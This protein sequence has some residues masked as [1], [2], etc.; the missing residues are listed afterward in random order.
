MKKIF[1]IAVSLITTLSTHPQHAA[2]S[3]K[4][5]P[6]A[7]SPELG[8][9]LFGDQGDGDEGQKHVAN[10]MK[11]FCQTTRCDFGLILGDNF[12][13]N[14]VRG[15][16]DPQF[17][18]AFE[19]P[20]SPLAIPFYAVLGNHDYGYLGVKGNI[21]AQVD[22]TQKSKFWKMP[23]RYYAFEEKGVQFVALD[24]VALEDEVQQEEWMVATL[25]ESKAKYKVV[26]GHFPIHSGGI[27]GDTP[28]MRK[29]ISPLLCGRAS[30]YVSGHDH[31]LQH[32]KTDCG[33][34]L[35]VSGAASS[36]RVVLDTK[37]SEF[38]K[39]TLGFAYLT[40]NSAGELKVS[41]VNDQLQ[42]LA[43]FPLPAAGAVGSSKINRKQK[44][45]K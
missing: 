9:L 24:T 22:Y 40:M 26:F 6:V 1:Y 4:P 17:K 21:Q 7:S 18:S 45:S 20:Y 25:N 35:V 5:T 39:S 38:S 13:P 11:R 14:G 28:F 15:A 8:V 42:T 16:D 36:H 27:H 29:Y 2:G 37:Q 32:L 31:D 33:V 23:A 30:V 34:P 41:Y 12:Y 3:D 43:I 44:L 10:A 19:E